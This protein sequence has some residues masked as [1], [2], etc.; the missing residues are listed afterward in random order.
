MAGEELASGIAFMVFSQAIGPAV[1][2]TLYNVIFLSTLPTQIAEF[3][4]HA[5]AEAISDAGASGFRSVVSP[6]DL[7]G[8]LV[9]YSNS[10]DR[11]YYLAAPFAALCW[12]ASWGMGW[13]DIRKRETGDPE[14]KANGTDGHRSAEK[15]KE[16]AGGKEVSS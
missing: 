8:V 3:A 16:A 15:V 14:A 4:P 9:A 11:I 10:L 13:N 6:A 5:N 7:D 12:I 2:N 1:A